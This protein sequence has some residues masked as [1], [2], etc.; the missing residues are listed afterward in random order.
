MLKF[1]GI[2][3]NQQG[4]PE[5]FSLSFALKE[6]LNACLYIHDFFQ[7]DL[8]KTTAA[9]ADEINKLFQ[10]TDQV[11]CKRFRLSVSRW[12]R[13]KDIIQFFYNDARFIKDKIKIARILNTPKLIE[14]KWQLIEPIILRVYFE[15]KA[16]ERDEQLSNPESELNL[17][18]Q[19]VSLFFLEQ[20]DEVP[21]AN[22]ELQFVRYQFPKIIWKKRDGFNASSNPFWLPKTPY[23]RASYLTTRLISRI[24]QISRG[25]TNIIP[26]SSPS[27]A[28][29]EM[30]LEERPEKKLP[31]T[32]SFNILYPESKPNEIRL[33]LEGSDDENSQLS[34][35]P[36]TAAEALFSLQR[37]V[38]KRYSYDGAKHLF[39]IFRQLAEAAPNDVCGF[40]LGKHF[41]LVCKI[42]KEGTCSEKQL[43][44]FSGI[45]QILGRLKVNRFWAGEGK[46][47]KITN[48][49]ML[50]I[51]SE[52][53]SSN[54]LDIVKKMVLDPLF[55]P[56]AGNPFRLGT[57]LRL[58]SKKLFQESVQKHALLLGVSS[59]M[60]GTWLNNFTRE[61]GTALKTSRE[62]I[63]GCALNITPASKYK[64]LD[65]LK[66]ELAYM[67]EKCY[68]SKYIYRQDANGNPW[69]DLHQFTAPDTVM[70]RI[71]EKIQ[72][73]EAAHFSERLIA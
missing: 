10:K 44:I 26:A 64:I 36:E 25:S 1:Y 70:Q 50:E 62:I 37:M 8:Q 66:S 65:K 16:K 47:K 40:D 72:L 20:D 52:S 22:L 23:C 15:L 68:I 32:F 41:R 49:F 43:T 12:F 54:P 46:K 60:T 3:F 48:S 71:T 2:R 6:S 55:F 57:H 29:K 21:P 14:D 9:I 13:A 53:T 34:M 11:K 31:A 38:Q 24:H 35:I 61:K 42:S 69:N 4:V 56:G 27:Q 58:M 18:L 59:F 28:Q 51:G 67:K 17:I 7:G 39:G 30:A 5:R 19:M 73:A 33:E 45:F 63:E